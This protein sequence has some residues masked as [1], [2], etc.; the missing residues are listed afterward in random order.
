L[1]A[2]LRGAADRA[3]AKIISSVAEAVKGFVGTALPSDDITM[4]A[5]RRLDPSAV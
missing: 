1:E 5:V 4:I 2:A 3:S